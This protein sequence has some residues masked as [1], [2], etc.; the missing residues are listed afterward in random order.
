MSY[1]H[2]KSVA[3]GLIF[4]S[5]LGDIVETTG[6]SEPFDYCK[7]LFKHGVIVIQGVFR[8]KGDCYPADLDTYRLCDTAARSA[9]L[10][11]PT[12]KIEERSMPLP[13]AAGY[14]LF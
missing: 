6:E 12:I 3:K 13:S 2:Q 14:Y 8:K 7:T 10:L 11:I 4:E 1:T 9:P 5:P